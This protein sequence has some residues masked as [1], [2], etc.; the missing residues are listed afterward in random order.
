VQLQEL[1]RLHAA[2]NARR[3]ELLSAVDRKVDREMVERLFNKFRS[4]I[5][6]VNE[7]VNELAGMMGNCATQR[8]V[9]AV[10]HVV[11]QMPVL[12]ETSAAVKVGPECI[13]CGRMKSALAGQVPAAA[14]IAGAGITANVQTPNDGGGFVYGDGGAYRARGILDSFSRLPPLSGQTARRAVKTAAHP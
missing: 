5:L 4:L 1:R 13:C 11:T 7:R 8:E 3:D 14:A 9:D 12:G 2:F 6:G 10:A